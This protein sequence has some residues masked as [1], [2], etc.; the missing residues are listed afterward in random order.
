MI[1]LA[2][3]LRPWNQEP[4][5]YGGGLVHDRVLYGG[6]MGLMEPWVATN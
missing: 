3:P 6:P 4:P 2:D 1:W 5:P